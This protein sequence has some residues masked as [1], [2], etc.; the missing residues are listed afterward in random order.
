VVHTDG[1]IVA[2]KPRTVRLRD[3]EKFVESNKS[4]IQ[5]KLEQRKA[6]PIPELRENSKQHFE[7]HKEAAL[8]LVQRKITQWNSD[9]SYV[10]NKVS[11]KRLRS[12]WGS[13]SS[14]RNL[15]FN[16]KILFLP[17]PLQDYL[18]VHELCHLK[19]LNHSRRFWSLVKESLPAYLDSKKLIRQYW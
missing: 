8:R 18:V 15:N 19:E 14:Q 7:D 10:Y 3:L 13:C 4:W 9:R 1:S 5:Q 16:Y 12:R 11:V 17:E 6:L 2:T